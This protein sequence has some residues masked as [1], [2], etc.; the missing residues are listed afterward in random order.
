ML[1][2]VGMQLAIWQGK[3]AIY[4]YHSKYVVVM[5]QGADRANKTN[6]VQLVMVTVKWLE[7]KR[8]CQLCSLAEELLSMALEC[9]IGK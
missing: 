3:T 9:T 8:Y 1:V 2:K 5:V 4:N 6:C 7:W